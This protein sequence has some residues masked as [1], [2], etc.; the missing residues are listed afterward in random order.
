MLVP[1]WLF[2]YY[3]VWSESNTFSL[4]QA[5]QSF[6]VAI[7]T[8]SNPLRTRYSITHW[9]CRI[10][11][12]QFVHKFLPRVLWLLPWNSLTVTYHTVCVPRPSLSF[13]IGGT[14]SETS[15]PAPLTRLSCITGF[16]SC[17]SAS[18]IVPLPMCTQNGDLVALCQQVVAK[19]QM[20][21]KTSDHFMKEILLKWAWLK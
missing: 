16:N 2:F 6:V 21:W 10:C 19:F 7:L 1:C 11:Q 12:C 17:L 4:S 20:L 15:S 8:D 18:L 13:C 14:G 3:S 9:F 5:A